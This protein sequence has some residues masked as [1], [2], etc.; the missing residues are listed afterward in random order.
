MCHVRTHQLR[1]NG[2]RIK[3]ATSQ[4]T[5]RNFIVSRDCSLVIRSTVPQLV[6]TGRHVRNLQPYVD[7]STHSKLATLCRQ[8]DTLETW[9]LCRHTRNLRTFVD[10]LETCVPL[11]TGR[12]AGNLIPYV[13]TFEICNLMS[14][15]R[16]AR[17]RN[18]ATRRSQFC[19]NFSAYKFIGFYSSAIT[20]IR[21][22]PTI[23]RVSLVVV[24]Y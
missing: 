17:N 4:L 9:Y 19:A 6:S 10:T 5:S 22:L 21:L 14:T 2:R 11:S 7:R 16:H 20:R 1:H 24:R 23:T 8:I 15:G 18:F 13:D 3:M 12:H